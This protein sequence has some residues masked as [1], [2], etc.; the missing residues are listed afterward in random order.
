M[1]E[2][3]VVMFSRPFDVNVCHD[4]Q[5]NVWVA[6]CDALGL[7]T[8]AATYEELT[9]RVWEIAP[10]LYVMNGL[11]SNPSRISLS[12]NQEQSYSDRIAL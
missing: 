1:R 7:V 11:G 9:E 2:L 3:A 5:D 6:Q 10:E 4:H 12:F 8:E